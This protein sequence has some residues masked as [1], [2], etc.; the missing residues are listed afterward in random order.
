MIE[1]AKHAIGFLLS[2]IS[3]AV[4][5]AS[6]SLHKE[7]VSCVLDREPFEGLICFVVGL[8]FDVVRFFI[9]IAG[10]TLMGFSA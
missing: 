9:F 7:G 6:L 10:Y 5:L 2:G 3:I 4:F 1:L 8:F